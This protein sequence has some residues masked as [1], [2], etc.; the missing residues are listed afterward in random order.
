M[1]HPLMLVQF[2]EQPPW[3]STKEEHAKVMTEVNQA[4]GTMWAEQMLPGHFTP[5]AAAMYGYRNRR[6]DTLKRKL[7]DASRGQ[8]ILGGTVPNVWSGLMMRAVLASQTIVARPNRVTIKLFGPRYLYQFDKRKGQPDKAREITT[9]AS[10]EVT[11]LEGEMERVYVEVFQR[12]QA[13][14]TTSFG[15][16]R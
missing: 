2:T 13:S 1:V 8:A 3:E 15:G 5:A 14:K 6:T 11:R 7:R 12:N 16:S 4:A 10:A 9:V